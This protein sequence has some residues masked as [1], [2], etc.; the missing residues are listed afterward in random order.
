MSFDEALA[1]A[2]Q[3]GAKP[4]VL[5]GNGF[6]IACR[7]DRFTYGALLDEATFEDA[8]TDLQACGC[9]K[10]VRAAGGQRRL[11]V[12]RCVVGDRRVEAGV[13]A[14][15]WSLWEWFRRLGGTH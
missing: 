2:E 6:S 11:L 3:Y 5:L 7:A 4:H 12:S 8:T 13:F 10:R 1:D 14:M 9:R 15:G